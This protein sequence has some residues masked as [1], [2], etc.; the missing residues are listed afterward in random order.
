[1]THYYQPLELTG[2]G[3]TPE[4]LRRVRTRARLLGR[5]RDSEHTPRGIHRAAGHQQPEVR[6]G[7]F[8]NVKL[9]CVDTPVAKSFHDALDRCHWRTWQQRG[10][11]A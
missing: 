10:T 1:M 9:S 11:P 8:L 2:W 6:R 3:G 4:V 5:Q 7:A